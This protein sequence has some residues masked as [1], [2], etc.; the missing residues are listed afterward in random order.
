MK[1]ILKWIGILLLS[2]F[3]FAVILAIVDPSELT[4]EERADYEKEVALKEKKEAEKKDSAKLA[5]LSKAIETLDEFDANKISK[6]IADVNISLVLLESYTILATSNDTSS[7]A[8]IKGK[9]ILLKEKIAKTQSVAL[10]LFRKTLA[11]ELKD[12]LWENDIDVILSGSRND[13]LTFIGG[14]F[15]AN[16]NKQEFTDAFVKNNSQFRFKRLNYKWIK[17]ESEFTYYDLNS[18]KDSELY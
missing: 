12:K 3:A 13:I 18:K 5:T 2:F 15:V 4:P 7:N 16:K 9:A 6:S 14:T 11:N 17:S 1:K 8:E 10:P